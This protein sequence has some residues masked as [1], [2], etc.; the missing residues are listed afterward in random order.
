MAPRRSLAATDTTVGPLAFHA[1]AE[2]RAESLVVA[3]KA[4]NVSGGTVHLAW[5]ACSLSPRLYA[6]D[7]AMHAPVYDW[8]HHSNTTPPGPGGRAC[9]MY[10]ATGNIA[11][12]DSLAPRELTVA[13]STGELARDGVRPG[14]YEVGAW[15]R[16]NG[17]QAAGAAAD[18][19]LV[20]IGTLEVPR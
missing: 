19:M 5:G 10:L 3:V 16:L 6:P 12:G 20:R 2:I 4:R 15:L 14:E 8:L 11:P 18:S 7:S 9:P 13:V 17:L 1:T